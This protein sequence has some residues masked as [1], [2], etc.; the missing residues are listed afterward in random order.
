MLLHSNN[1]TE[2]FNPSTGLLTYP[3]QDALANGV[4]MITITAGDTAGNVQVMAYTFTVSDH[5]PSIEHSPLT[6]IV[7]EE[8]FN[9]T[10]IVSDDDSIAGVFLYYRPKMNEME[11]LVK[12]MSINSSGIYSTSIP[13]MYCTSSGI[14]YYIKAIDDKANE[15]ITNS[16]DI[17]IEDNTGP[18]LSGDISVTATSDKLLIQWDKVQD[19]DLSGYHI[20]LGPDMNHLE[21]YKDTATANS[22]YLESI[23]SETYIGISAYDKSDNI[24]NQIVDRIKAP[25]ILSIPD[26]TMKETSVNHSISF[27]VTSD[28]ITEHLTVSAWSSNL[29]LVVSEDLMITQTGS[30]YE[31]MLMPV[32]DTCGSSIITVSA[33]NKFLTST[34][35]FD[36]I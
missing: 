26:Q 23:D 24:G 36:L 15:S 31:L 27:T 34:T 13:G 25:D 6:T 16:I 2:Y 12:K 4:H 19:M 22:F 32:H 5:P 8:P 33:G 14:R 17:S 18:K 30:S 1:Y 3:V 7:S 21:F 35:A 20:Y 28:L 10:A 11:Y 9:I 29:P